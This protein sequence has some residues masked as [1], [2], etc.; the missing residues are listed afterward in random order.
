MQVICEGFKERVAMWICNVLLVSIAGS[1]LLVGGFSFP[2]L[3]AAEPV[4]EEALFSRAVPPNVLIILDNSNSMDEDFYGN[5]VGSYAPGSKSVEGKRVLNRLVNTYV[6]AMRIGLMTYLLPSV[7]AGYIANSALFVSY[8][9]KSYCPNPPDA[10]VEYCRTGSRA[11]QEICQATCSAGNSS[12]RADYIDDSIIGFIRG[13]AQR[14]KY[15]GLVYPKTNRLPS[16][17]DPGGYI[18]Y[19][20]ALPSYP[21]NQEGILFGVSPSYTIDDTWNESYQRYASKTGTSDG[22]PVL[23]QAIDDGYAGY[24]DSKSL[25]RTDSDIAMGYNEFGKRV[26]FFDVGRSWKANTSPGSGYLHVP[27]GRN[28]KEAL[29]TKLKICDDPNPENCLAKGDKAR[30]DFYM[31]CTN[32]IDPNKCSYILNAGLTPAAGTLESAI[33]YFQGTYPSF[34]SPIDSTLAQCQKNFI[35][36]VTDGLPSADGKGVQ[37]ATDSLLPAVIQKLQ[38]LRSLT[39]GSY[40]YDIKTYIVGVGLTP[41]AKSI[42]DRMAIAGG[43]DVNGKAYYA[44]RPTDL[45]DALNQIFTDIQSSTYSFP[46]PSISSVRL[47]DE[48]FLYIGSF[49]PSSDPFWRGHLRKIQ[50]QDDGSLG[51]EL[52]DGGSVLENT[53]ASDRTIK[54]YIGGGLK[55]FTESIDPRYFGDGLQSDD[56]KLIVSYIRGE[57]PLLSGGKTM[58]NPDSPRKLGDIFHSTPVTIATPSLFFNDPG[59]TNQAFAK[60]RKNHQ[61]TSRDGTRIIIAGANDGQLHAFETGGGHEVWSFIPPN[62]L[63][64][65][66]NIVHTSDPTPRKHTYFVDGPVSAAEVWLPDVDSDG[67]RKNDSEWRTLL[68]FG[69]GMGVRGPGGSADYLWNSSPFCDQKN[70]D[71][72][73]Q[74][75][76]DNYCGYYALDVTQTTQYPLFRWFLKPR[77]SD[78]PYIGE[79]WSKMAMGKVKINGNEKWVGFIGGGY[80]MGTPQENDTR[81]KGFF[82]VDLRTGDIL[83]SYTAANNGAMNRIPGSP[84]VVDR[85]HDGFIDTAYAGD[86]AGNLWKFTFCPFN[87]DPAKSKQC[88]TNNWSAMQLFDPEGNHAP[89]F[90]TPAVAKDTGNYWV[91]WG[92]GDK[93]NPNNPINYAGGSEAVQNRFF[94]LKDQN[95]ASAYKVSNLTGIGGSGWY[96]DLTGQES[97]LSDATVYKGIVFFTGYTPS[98]SPCGAAGTGTLYGIAMMPVVIQGRSYSGGMSVFS[99]PNIPLGSGIPSAP[100]ISQ[101]P[102]EGTR[103]EGNTPDVYVAVSGGAGSETTV[104]S[105]SR[106]QLKELSDV[107]AGSGPSTFIIHWKDRRVQPY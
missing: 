62:I 1:F 85:D 73:S 72:Y 21:D 86:L 30:E 54:T 11:A 100:V 60:F 40:T 106:P 15:C 29:L 10:C 7:T 14:D 84:A 66:S 83:W 105:T 51:G 67:T 18:Y 56:V 24:I 20:Q 37:G 32:T 50:I 12:F 6:D 44:D 71:Q 75:E 33:S 57:N 89:I 101:K 35:V 68:V 79:P 78:A 74:G 22:I 55:D 96:M 64:K 27:V 70:K 81:G 36:Y 63:P 103:S 98:A 43:T 95:P 5:G 3:H 91:F 53:A 87:P 16:P 80:T 4:G 65:L 38:R 25:I 94:A 23:V 13:T 31:S 46:L 77:G 82:V 2:S 49:E 8:E 48:N 76:N 39:S 28:Q 90:T 9:P 52:W 47:Q 107:L 102:I 17:S 61:R 19:K 42:L 59:E 97:V 58:P 34:P 88:N 45:E 92:T 93:A 104:Q 69:L 99:G 41:E 26:V